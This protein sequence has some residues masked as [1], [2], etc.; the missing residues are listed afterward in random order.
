MNHFRYF[1]PTN[2]KILQTSE[3]CDACNKTP[4]PSGDVA[5][6]LL[7]RSVLTVEFVFFEQLVILS[8]FRSSNYHAAARLLGR[9]AECLCLFS[10]LQGHLCDF[11]YL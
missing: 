9:T 2:P 6:V 3:P 11:A 1:I 8:F 5:I 7:L 4:C 10:P